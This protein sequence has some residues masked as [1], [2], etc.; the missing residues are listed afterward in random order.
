MARHEKVAVTVCAGEFKQGAISA[1]R[2][3]AKT[4]GPQGLFAGYGSFMLRDLP[5]D[6][7]EFVAYE[8]LKKAWVSTTGSDIK[9]HES[10]VIGEL[11]SCL[12]DAH[13]KRV[14]WQ[15]ARMK[16][17]HSAALTSSC[18]CCQGYAI[19]VCYLMFLLHAFSGGCAG[20]SFTV[21]QGWLHPWW[22]AWAQQI[23]YALERCLQGLWLALSQGWP[24][25]LWTSSR[26][27]S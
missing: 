1:V 12:L 22:I 4:E 17:Q 8:Q 19:E 18:C 16:A 14:K 20:C 21:H 6:A 27:G 7:I 11:S 13:V 25:L 23:K 15:P 24:P 2:T 9:A 5:F 10:A 26:L 3:I